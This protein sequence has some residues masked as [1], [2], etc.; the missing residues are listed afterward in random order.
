[1]RLLNPGYFFVPSPAKQTSLPGTFMVP[2][3]HLKGIHYPCGA[4]DTTGAVVPFK[5]EAEAYAASTGA[6]WGDRTSK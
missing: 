4:Q 5:S 2:A 3:C 6:L 1:M